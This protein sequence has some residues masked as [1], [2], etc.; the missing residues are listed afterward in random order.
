MADVVYIGKQHP[1]LCMERSGK[2]QQG[3]RRVPKDLQ[4]ERLRIRGV[5]D[6]GFPKDSVV[7]PHV[8]MNYVA[9]SRPGYRAH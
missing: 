8:Q 4:R 3:R 1:S 5:T 9:Y 6:R 2:T 7:A